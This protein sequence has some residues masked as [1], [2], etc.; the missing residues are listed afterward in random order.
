MLVFS[1]VESIPFFLGRVFF[2]LC[3]WLLPSDIVTGRLETGF[4]SPEVNAQRTLFHSMILNH[5]GYLGV[6]CHRKER[7]VLLFIR[8]LFLSFLSFN[9]PL[10]FLLLPPRLPPAPQHL[11]REGHTSVTII[12]LDKVPP[13]SRSHDTK[14]PPGFAVRFLHSF[15][16]F[17][18]FPY[19]T[20]HSCFSPC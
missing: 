17:D 10:Q 13:N 4:H 2:T 19:L 5:D 11:A 8:F 14:T 1:R 15:S 16:Y 9:H 7:L 18:V 6:A 20:Q 3:S 12:M